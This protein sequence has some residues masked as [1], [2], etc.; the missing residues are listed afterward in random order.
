[1]ATEAAARVF[2]CVPHLPSGLTLCA[3]HGEETLRLPRAGADSLASAAE[4]AVVN[5]GPCDRR[6]LWGAWRSSGTLT[7]G[8]WQL[9]KPP[10]SPGVRWLVAPLAGSTLLTTE[11]FYHLRPDAGDWGALAACPA[12]PPRHP[13][14]PPPPDLAWVMYH[15]TPAPNVAPILASGFNPT[16]QGME[17]RA[18][19]LGLFL[20]AVR[21]SMFSTYWSKFKDNNRHKEGA[22]FRCLV[23]CSAARHKVLDVTGAR[24]VP[25]APCGKCDNDY[26]LRV[27]N[28]LKRR[29]VDHRGAW[30]RDYDTLE[31]PPCEWA[32]GKRMVRTMELVVADPRRVHVLDVHPVDMATRGAHY[33]PTRTDHRVVL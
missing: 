26:R 28:P 4:T 12:T 6:C 33:E 31:V 1:M 13:G 23:T 32:P 10:D 7:V 24:E 8:F 21:F 2:L 22:V 11:G 16:E 3:W 14:A 9:E 30:M 5:F 17:G 27:S 29:L 19:Y 20:K 15:G 18:V 25:C